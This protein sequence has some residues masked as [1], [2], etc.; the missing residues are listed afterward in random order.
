MNFHCKQLN[1]PCRYAR[2]ACVVTGWV[3][4]YAGESPMLI[5]STWETHP[6]TRPGP[7]APQIRNFLSPRSFPTACRHDGTVSPP[8]PRRYLSVVPLQSLQRYY[9]EVTA[10]LRRGQAQDRERR[11]RARLPQSVGAQ[12]SGLSYSRLPLGGRWERGGW[13]DSTV[14]RHTTSLRYDGLAHWTY[15]PECSGAQLSRSSERVPRRGYPEAP[16]LSFP[17]LPCSPYRGYNG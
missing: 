1:I 10:R 12:T 9:G 16:D 11:E 13:P 15:V 3:S 14:R 5:Q 17:I 2:S 8:Y 6:Y 7:P 4:Q